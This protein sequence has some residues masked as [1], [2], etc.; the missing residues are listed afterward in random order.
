M[1]H[2]PDQAKAFA[3]LIRNLKRRHKVTEPTPVD[4][5]T[6]VVISFL[7]WEST[8][9]KAERALAAIMAQV[10]DL[11]ELRISF[12][13]QIVAMI[14]SDY[15]L[16]EQRVGRMRETL[17]EI[18]RREHDWQPRSL[19]TKGKKEQRAYLESL[20][21]IPVYVVAQVMLLTYG[22]HAM[23]VDRKLVALLARE[24]CCDENADPAEVE[25]FLLRH[26]KAED[27]LNTHLLLQSWSD[28]S[29]ITS[30]ARKSA[31]RSA[32]PKK[33]K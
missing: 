11:N 19:A 31:S 8:V 5:T 28:N 15:P 24:G 23:P 1:K 2:D 25:N 21:G 17:N 10:V 6:Q 30:P 32:S 14:G 27:A 18:Y 33:K 22:G 3:A 26:V 9:R 29:R 16:A 12:P 4:A 7:Q 20:P 13:S